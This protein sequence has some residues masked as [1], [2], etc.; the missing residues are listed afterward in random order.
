MLASK[1]Q[2]AAFG[3]FRSAPALT[4]VFVAFDEAFRLE[5]V[6][7]EEWARYLTGGS[8]NS[9]TTF[10]AEKTVKNRVTVLNFALVCGFN[11]TG[12]RV[13]C[14]VCREAL[15]DDFFKAILEKN[16]GK[17]LTY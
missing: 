12:Q 13:S 9:A 15:A 8:L 4:E 3:A 7:D 1:D 11:T 14:D 10:Y 17:E 2:L 6:P 5:D 16:K